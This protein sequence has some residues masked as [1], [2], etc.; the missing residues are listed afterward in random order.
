MAIRGDSMDR[1]VFLICRRESR[2]QV[3]D[4]DHLLADC[5]DFQ[6]ASAAAA[7]L[8]RAAFDGGTPVRIATEGGF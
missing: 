7:R 8:A 5:A 1:R 4:G 6:L 3:F 2:W